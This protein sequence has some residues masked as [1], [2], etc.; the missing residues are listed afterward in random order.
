MDKSCCSPNKLSFP[1]LKLK[2]ISLKIKLGECI[3]SRQLIRVYNSENKNNKKLNIFHRYVPYSEKEAIISQLDNNKQFLVDIIKDRNVQFPHKLDTPYTKLIKL[4]KLNKKVVNLHIEENTKTTVPLNQVKECFY[5]NNKIIDYI[6][7]YSKKKENPK[8]RT[9]NHSYEVNNI[10]HLYNNNTT[11]NLSQNTKLS[12]SSYSNLTRK[13]AQVKK[14]AYCHKRSKSTENNLDDY[15]FNS[16]SYDIK[17][18]NFSNN[19]NGCS[20]VSKDEIKSN[21]RNFVSRLRKFDFNKNFEL[22]CNESRNIVN[23]GIG[24]NKVNNIVNGTSPI[25]KK[26]NSG[27][28]IKVKSVYCIY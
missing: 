5:H 10:N 21:G 9:R 17:G 18:N 19:I 25:R 8:S 13:H 27:N 16:L 24:Y 3:S 22:S 14:K 12:F 11:Y 26:L 15:V 20:I 1:K 23:K 7:N 2:D 28:K 6:D 4:K